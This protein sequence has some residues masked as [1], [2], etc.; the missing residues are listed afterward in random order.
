MNTNTTVNPVAIL[1]DIEE[2]CRASAAGLPHKAEA[3]NT[4]SGIGFRIGDNYLVTELGEAVEILDVPVMSRVPLTMPWMLGV[5]NVRG[6]LLPVIDVQGML[7][8]TMTQHTVRTRVLV[9]DHDGM[10]SGLVV[11]EVLGLK[12]FTDGEYTEEEAPV[13]DY[14]RPYTDHGFRRGDRVWAVFSLYAL[15]DAPQF[16]QAAV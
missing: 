4:W 2:R 12:H 13:E 5:A 15:V 16:L 6:N 10:F 9:F 8:G 7:C 1:R 14:L 3:G 11:D